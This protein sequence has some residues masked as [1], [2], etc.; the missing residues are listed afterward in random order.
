M[1]GDSRREL[2]GRKGGQVTGMGGGGGG[3][4]VAEL[5]HIDRREEVA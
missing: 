5:H 1:G 4:G 3:L 2:C